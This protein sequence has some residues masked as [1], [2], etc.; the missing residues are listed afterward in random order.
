[1]SQERRSSLKNHSN[2][3]LENHTGKASVPAQTH[4]EFNRNQQAFFDKAANWF[5]SDEAVPEEVQPRLR[6]IVQAGTPNTKAPRFLDV[7]C[8]AG[9][10]FFIYA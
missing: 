5:A 10:L 6:Q 4:E 8:G 3:V 1:M 9:V 7:G 2:T